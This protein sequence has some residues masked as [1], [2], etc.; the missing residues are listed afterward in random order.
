MIFKI[1]IQLITTQ[2][3]YSIAPTK[4]N[5]CRFICITTVAFNF[6]KHALNQS[7]TRRSMHSSATSLLNKDAA[8]QKLLRKIIVHST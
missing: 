1:K 4:P 2:H 6:Y 8:Y 3:I 5:G 7:H